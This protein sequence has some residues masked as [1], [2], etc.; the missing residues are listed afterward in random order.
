MIQIRNVLQVRTASSIFLFYSLFGLCPFAATQIQ[1]T[2]PPN[3]PAGVPTIKENVRQVLVP[4]VVMDKKGRP[5]GGLA[6]SDFVVFEDDVPQ[7]I[8]AFRK[9]F[10]ASL[11]TAGLPSGL[12]NLT[13]A[14]PANPGV[15]PAGR[16]GPDSPSR[17]YLICVDTLHSSF[18]NVAQA[19]QALT[20]FF[21][22]EHDERAQ[23]ALFNLSRRIEVIQDSTR[24]P[25]LVL[26]ALDSKRFRASILSG[27]ASNIES[28]SRQLREMLEGFSPLTCNEPGIR[29]RGQIL[30]NCSNMK[31][32]VQRFIFRSKERTAV[33]TRIFLQELKTILTAMSGMPTQR[34]LI[35]VSDGFNLVPGRELSGIASVY[36]PNDPEW[37]TNE[38]DT[39]PELNELLRLAQ[40]SNIV[41]DGLDSRGV[42]DAAATG[43]ESAQNSI[44]Q[45]GTAMFSLIHNDNAVAWE[46]GSGMAQLAQATG[47]IYF[48][49][50]NDLLAGLH[51][52]FDD[53]RERY[54]IA[55]A[56]TNAAVDGKYRKIRVEVKDKRLRVYAKTGY[57]STGN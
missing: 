7:H 24:D 41:V 42:Y 52:A 10:D 57:W 34:T 49:G 17:T 12:P 4:A 27:E 54:V 48:H 28:E 39:Q 9:T 50:S 6:Q 5:V 23:Y 20:K 1:S 21:Q 11:E 18:G 8:V 53:E 32:Q 33:L 47:G 56:P 30:D 22:H 44:D 2:P 31:Q 35:L 13:K 40:K 26:L 43:S 16:V 15:A 37:R 14:G 36:F 38:G 46:N 51:R 29:S 25:S 45:N 3:D 19:R 55:Y